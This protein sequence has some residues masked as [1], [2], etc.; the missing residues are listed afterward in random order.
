MQQVINIYI[1]MCTMIKAE[2]DIKFVFVAHVVQLFQYDLSCAK[3]GA[4]R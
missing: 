2:K 1:P 4:L 3:F